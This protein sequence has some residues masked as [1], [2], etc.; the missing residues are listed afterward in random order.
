MKSNCRTLTGYGP[1]C[2]VFLEISVER[3]KELRVRGLCVLE[4]VLCRERFV[5]KLRESN[6]KKITDLST[7][8]VKKFDGT[9]FLGW[10][11]QMTQIFVASDELD[12]VNGEK[13]MPQDCQSAEGKA[14]IK[15]NA[16]AMFFISSSMEYTQLEPLLTSVTAKQM[17]DKLVAIHSR[18]SASNKLMLTQKFHEYRMAPTDS[19]V[20]HVARVQ[21]MA[22]Q[23]LDLGENLSDTTIMAKVLAG[24]TAKFSSFQTAWDS[25]EPER[26]TIENL[27]ER[28]LREES[29]LNAD[30]AEVSAFA[31][32]KVTKTSGEESKTKPKR[33]KNNRK[34]IEKKD[35]ECF[36]F[37]KKGHFAR[38]CP[39][40]KHNKDKDEDKSEHDSGSS[41]QVAFAAFCANVS[42]TNGQSHIEHGRYKRPDDKKRR[43]FLAV[44]QD[45][46]WYIDSGCSKHVTFR[47]DWFAEYRPRKD[48]ETIKLGDD[49][50]CLVTGEGTVIVDRLVDGV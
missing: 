34:K 23:L 40:R 43:A 30:T 29:R 8:Q 44:K 37:Q 33:G 11:F 38:Q 46:I 27:Q 6:E 24:L 26:Q 36:V 20:Q 9:N 48:G 12:I 3:E 42:E 35:I 14:W 1:S 5:N 49:G 13:P 10:K 45:D 50:E 16:K 19:V 39:Q 31:A 22:T 15:D 32:M 28:L 4:T 18:K 21:N 25:V 7:K 2:V 47:R 41:R 17:W